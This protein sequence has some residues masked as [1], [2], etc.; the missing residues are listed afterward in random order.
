MLSGAP[1]GQRK[2]SECHGPDNP[3]HRQ[4]KGFL[5]GLEGFLI[6]AASNKPETLVK[7]LFTSVWHF[8][9]MNGSR[10]LKP[11]P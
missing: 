4:E 10:S 6:R 7:K 8:F 9:M 1:L 3:Q 11:I 2:I 5:I